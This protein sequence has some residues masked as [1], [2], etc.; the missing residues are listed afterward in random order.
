[1]RTLALA[2][3]MAASSLAAAGCFDNDAVTTPDPAVPEEPPP[4]AC[5]PELLPIAAGYVRGLAASSTHVWVFHDG[6]LRGYTPDGGDGR[7]I[8][9]H[10]PEG[11]GN[12]SSATLSGAT[13]DYVLVSY[14]GDYHY[15]WMWSL[16]R[17]DPET[18]ERITIGFHGPL[19]FSGP[20]VFSSVAEGGSDGPEVWLVRNGLDGTGYL[21]LTRM[22]EV[23]WYQH[24]IPA[25]QADD[26]TVY[27]QHGERRLSRISIDGGEPQMLASPA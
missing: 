13:D 1:M 21:P 14:S 15:W 11:A 8:F 6:E 7:L 24:S 22:P 17:I 16:F 12:H 19:T 27:Y 3:I 18:T 20:Y 26:D 5:V 25:L 9:E 4:R 10:K 2:S 23:G